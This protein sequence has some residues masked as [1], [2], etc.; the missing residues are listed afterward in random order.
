MVFMVSFVDDS[1]DGLNLNS[2]F[3]T[4]IETVACAHM[5]AKD[6]KKQKNNNE[7]SN[8]PI[9]LYLFRVIQII[10]YFVLLFLSLY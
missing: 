10:K 1:L 6:E 4:D 7:K 9:S 2:L 5:I 3:F 8:K